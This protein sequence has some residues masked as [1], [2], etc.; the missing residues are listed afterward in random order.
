MRVVIVDQGAAGSCSY[1]RI[2]L[3]AVLQAW[4]L[5]F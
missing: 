2:V 5:L 3:V 1:R 4:T